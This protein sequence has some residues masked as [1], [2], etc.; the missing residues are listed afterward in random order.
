MRDA[1]CRYRCAPMDVWNLQDTESR[2][3][4]REN[5]LEAIKSELIRARNHT[6]HLT[7]APDLIMLSSHAI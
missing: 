2:A 3:E 4:R 5:A 7:L 1:R 6:G